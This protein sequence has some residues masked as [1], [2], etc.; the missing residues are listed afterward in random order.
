MIET[1]RLIITKLSMDMAEAIHLN[2]LDEDM[3][4]FVP[5]EVFRT[6]DEAEKAIEFLMSRYEN[7]EGPW[8]YPILTKTQINIGYIQVVKW[9]KDWEIGFHVAKAYTKQG[10]ASEALRAFLPFIAQEKQLTKIWGICLMENHASIR[11]LMN[12][13]FKEVSRGDGVYQ[14]KQKKIITFVWNK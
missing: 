2:S 6:I 13:D 11:V 1:P 12:C 5:D 14:G 8:V 10:Y 7:E 9:E 4:Q 3:V